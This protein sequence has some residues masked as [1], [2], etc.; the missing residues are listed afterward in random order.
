M[1]CCQEFLEDFLKDISF[2]DIKKIL[3]KYTDDELDNVIE[4][5][6]F[7][8]KKEIDTFETFMEKSE[9]CESNINVENLFECFSSNLT[10]V[11]YKEDPEE[12]HCYE[13][14][15]TWN[16]VYDVRGCDDKIKLVHTTHSSKHTYTS[17]LCISFQGGYF[18]ISEGDYS[19]SYHS[20]SPLFKFD[21]ILDIC[22][23]P[24]TVDTMFFLIIFLLHDL[25]EQGDL[26]ELIEE[27][28]LDEFYEDEET[29]EEEETDDD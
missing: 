10:L 19:K 5:A 29:N 28:Y 1:S 18:E 8:K 3:D 16:L 20:T 4:Y 27:T 6:S 12:W 15:I 23:Q 7:L 11:E 9:L 17:Y 26:R 13:D 22:G 21:K 2:E 25:E 14:G 24:I